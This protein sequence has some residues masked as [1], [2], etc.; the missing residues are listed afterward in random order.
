MGTLGQFI[1]LSFLAGDL[2]IYEWIWILDSREMIFGR[3]YESSS[4]SILILANWFF[5]NCTLVYLITCIC[6]GTEIACFPNRIFIDGFQLYVI[7]IGIE[8]YYDNNSIYVLNLKKKDF[9]MSF[10]T[11]NVA[12]LNK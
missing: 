7:S 8:N 10:S 2:V 12:V 3:I 5:L 9:F 4:D 1:G 6:N 11:W